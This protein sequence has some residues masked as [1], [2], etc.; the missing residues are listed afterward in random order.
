MSETAAE[1]LLSIRDLQVEFATDAGPVR[2]V[3]GVDLS[4]AAG[5]T[6]AL[7]GESGS[8]KS[9][10][11]MS[12]MRLTE[13]RIAEGS[14]RFQGRDLAHVPEAEMRSIRGGQ[15]GMI[16][17]EPMTSLNPV[18]TVGRQIEEVLRLHQQLS[19]PG[20]RAQALELLKRVGISAP[21]RRIAQYPHELSG[22]MKQR[23][24]LAIAIACRPRLL[25]ADEP[26]TALDVTIQAQIIELLRSLQREFGMAVLLITHDLGVV[27]H[28]AQ[29][30]LVM[31]AGKIVEQG[32]VR[33]VFKRASHPYTQALLAALPDPQHP[34][35]RLAAIPGRVPSPSMLPAGCAFCARC[36]HAFEPCPVRQ[37]PLFTVGE[38]HRA[39]CF[40]RE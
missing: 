29:R 36:A 12:V 6:V 10:T 14:V 20:A 31:Y 19:A 13:G 18:F 27:A 30:V 39:A 1:P 34:K 28:F 24:M 22:G 33:D 9:V 21:E 5:E 4:I 26:T 16:F 3:R 8:G 17:Q 7:V 35:K 32:S 37:P 23:V 25:I 40:L 11:A 2:A 15:I 38:G